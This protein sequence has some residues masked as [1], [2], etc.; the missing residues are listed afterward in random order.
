MRP[1]FHATN[2]R[3]L[4]IFL[5]KYLQRI[6][7]NLRIIDL[8]GMEMM[9]VLHLIGC[10]I[11]IDVMLPVDISLRVNWSWSTALVSV[12]DAECSGFYEF[13]VFFHL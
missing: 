10:L 1:M 3:H 7:W 13:G 12:V 11:N 5:K 9:L 6:G 4:I 2:L 8:N